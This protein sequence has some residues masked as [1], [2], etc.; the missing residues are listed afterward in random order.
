M[1]I[2]TIDIQIKGAEVTAFDIDPSGETTPILNVVLA[3][4]IKSISQ[5]QLQEARK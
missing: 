5:E 4:R 1:R 2:T 3:K